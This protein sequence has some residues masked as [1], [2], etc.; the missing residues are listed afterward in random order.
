MSGPKRPVALVSVFSDKVLKR[1]LDE[2]AEGP[3]PLVADWFVGT[4]GVNKVMAERV[5][6]VFGCRYA[7]VFGIQP[8]TSMQARLQRRLPRGFAV[9]VGD[10]AHAGEIP[11]S[12]DG[13]T[14]PPRDRRAWGIELGRRFRDGLRP[15]RR[16]AFPI[17]VWQFDEI[18][19]E[20]GRSGSSNP[21]REFVGGVL[22][23][24][25][26]GRRELG[27][28]P[29][30]GFVW[31]ARS[32]LRPSALPG[33]PLEGDLPGFWRDVSRATL[34]LVG[35]EYPPFTGSP[36]SRSRQF[37]E[38]H[39]ALSRATGIRRSLGN[40]YIVGMTPG[41][42][43]FPG[44]GGNIAMRSPAEVSA[45]RNGFID[46]RIVEQRPAGF[47]QFNLA[48]ENARPNR[49]VDAVLSLHRASRQLVS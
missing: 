27:D 15:N 44:L 26:E 22:H 12:S 28:R 23:G 36:T 46:S 39:R 43:L 25:A 41:W 42:R 9:V 4:Y 38:G 33:L 17:E 1:I 7:P 34:F 18:L 10:A 2:I 13:L 29:Q 48:R 31:V 32:A 47:A 5:A 19:G 11:G 20:C 35:E 30:K 24:L 40:R 16:R 6:A 8:G 45:W 21:H 49:V 14:I 37:S 3:L